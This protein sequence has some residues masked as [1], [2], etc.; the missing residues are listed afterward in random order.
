MNLDAWA[1]IFIISMIVVNLG[2]G[3]DNTDQGIASS[4][5][6]PSLHQTSSYANALS[7]PE[8]ITSDYP[9]SSSSNPYK[10]SPFHEVVGALPCCGM[11]NA[12]T[13]YPVGS[14][15]FDTAITW[16]TVGCVAGIFAGAL[17]PYAGFVVGVSFKTMSPKIE[18]EPP[19]DLSKPW[20]PSCAASWLPSS[21]GSSW[22]DNANPNLPT[23]QETSPIGSSQSNTQENTP[24]AVAAH[25]R[26]MQS[27]TQA[28]V[29]ATNQPVSQ[30]K[31]APS[32]DQEKI[33]EAL[34]ANSKMLEEWTGGPLPGG[35]PTNKPELTPNPHSSLSPSDLGG[36]NFTSIKLNCISVCKNRSGGVNFDFLFKA[37]KA[38]GANRRTNPMNSTS[39]GIIAFMTGLALPDEVFWVNLNPTEPDRIIDPRLEQ[40]EVGRILLEADLQ[41]KKDDSRYSNPC[42]NGPSTAN[43]TAEDDLIKKKSDALIEH[44]MN[45]YPG[46]IKSIHNIEFKTV[47]RNWIT[48]D[49]IYAYTNG[50]QIYIINASLTVNT[51]TSN[52]S[53]FQ[54][55][56]QD[57][58]SISKECLEELNRS[59]EELNQYSKEL[60]E[61]ML[62]KYYIS[63][64]NNGE[65]YE[66]LREVYVALALAQWYKSRVPPE[67][68]IFKDNKESL[69]TAVT[70][71]SQPWSSRE[72]WNEYAYL[73]N[74]IKDNLYININDKCWKNSTTGSRLYFS[75][76][77]V[78]FSYIKIHQIQMP[79]T[80]NNEVNRAIA[81][82]FTN[83]GNDTLF[84]NRL[85]MK[86]RQ[87][88]QNSSYET[89]QSSGS[90]PQILN[91]DYFNEN[92]S[93]IEISIHKDLSGSEKGN[94]QN[95]TDTDNARSACP[96]G[97]MGPNEKGECFKMQITNKN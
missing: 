51:Q 35:V 24:I 65:K 81:N 36:V 61:R 94:S 73:F 40:T 97:W 25:P 22:L 46:E 62:N 16:G 18:D 72:I 44:C 5:T 47:M 86:M 34:K 1:L 31:T 57:M 3:F 19:V 11:F 45:K 58:G 67:I 28:T 33:S 88:T 8:M 52:L 77:G 50:T 74:N 63:N 59:T 49:E 10:G 76:G 75:S 14:K 83:D 37:Q 80:V 6:L 79:S 96:N 48:P 43:I 39:L 41:L 60:Y 85:H 15:Q 89:G 4:L 93:E 27:N 55:Y 64:V 87:N 30:P 91:Q 78:E 84:G 7:T 82:G 69:R 90:E 23:R 32:A 56:N 92:R 38:E 2:V 17:N 68:D 26:G 95:A 66:R 53:S 54:V 70:T 13:D 29:P 9:T 21:G 42:V 71:Y 20:Q 12:F